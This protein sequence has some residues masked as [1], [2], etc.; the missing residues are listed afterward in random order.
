[1]TCSTYH[2]LRPVAEYLLFKTGGSDLAP[3]ERHVIRE[4]L[5]KSTFPFCH[6]GNLQASRE[7]YPTRE[8]CK[9]AVQNPPFI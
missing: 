5:E 7:I 2:T 1:M 9:V 4:I 3:N 8:T 6:E